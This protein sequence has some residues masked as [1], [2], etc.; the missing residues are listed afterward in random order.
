V[1]RILVHPCPTWYRVSFHGG[2]NIR[3]L[4]HVEAN[5]TGETLRH[6]EMFPVCDHLPGPDG[7]VYLQ[8]GDGRGWVFDDSALLPD[9]PSVVRGEWIHVV[10]EFPANSLWEPMEEPEPIHKV[11]EKNTLAES[12]SRATPPTWY[13]VSFHGGVNIRELPQIESDRTGGTLQHNEIFAVCDESPGP[14]GRVY[15]QLADGRGWVFDDSALLPNDPSVVR[16]EWDAAPAN[17]DV[18][19]V[20]AFPSL[21]QWEPMEEPTE[22]PMQEPEAI[23]NVDAE[24]QSSA[25]SP[26]CIPAHSLP[27]WYGAYFRGVVNMREFLDMESSRTGDTLQ[28]SGILSVGDESAGTDGH[29]SLQLTHGRVFDDSA[30]LPNNASVSCPECI[31]EDAPAAA[32]SDVMQEVPADSKW[33]PLEEPEQTD[34]EEMQRGRHGGAKR[35]ICRGRDQA[36]SEEA[37]PVSEFERLHGHGSIDS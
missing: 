32:I 29:V 6:N 15:L 21:N 2:V 17:H 27:T 22:E 4:P 25:Q 23:E 10:P 5:R 7:R 20:P 28:T 37:D 13:R 18:S 19:V 31:D 1:Q 30:K 26:Q 11:M 24:S 12:Q 34:Q 36:P 14:D 35:W 9:D 16:G 8:L 33:E 3:E